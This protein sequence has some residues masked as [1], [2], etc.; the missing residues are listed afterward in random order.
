MQRSPR[1]PRTGTR[2][3]KALQSSDVLPKLD[4]LGLLSVGST[5]EELDTM[6][7]QDINTIGAV[8]KAI[9]LKPE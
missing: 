1:R 5:P 4:E 8:V 6:L 2:S 9:G 7:R 3:P